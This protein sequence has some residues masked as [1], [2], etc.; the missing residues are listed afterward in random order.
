MIMLS[1]NGKE[2]VANE[3]KEVCKKH[4]VHQIT[5]YPYT[6]LGIIERF[7][8]TIKAKIYQFQMIQGSLRYIDYLDQL[9]ENY[10][11]SFHHTIKEKPETLHYKK[12]DKVRV[13]IHISPFFPPDKEC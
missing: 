10:N 13:L 4:G 12:G 5:T 1:D 7:N 9:V 6:P 8:K 2:F 11:H 3:V